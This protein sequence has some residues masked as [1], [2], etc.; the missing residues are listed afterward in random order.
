LF[1]G[2]AFLLIAQAISERADLLLVTDAISDLFHDEALDYLL[3]G[4]SALDDFVG[5]S[6]TGFRSSYFLYDSLLLEPERQEGERESK[7]S[8]QV[9]LELDVAVTEKLFSKE[10]IPQWQSAVKAC[11]GSSAGQQLSLFELGNLCGLSPVET[12]LALLHSTAA[13]ETMLME[14]DGGFYRQ[15]GDLVAIGRTVF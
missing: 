15:P 11:L 5:G 14:S 8:S 1:G 4:V 7:P 10:D 13:G 9:Q 12:F 3:P 6:G 2:S